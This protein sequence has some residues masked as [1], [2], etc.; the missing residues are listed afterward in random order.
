[1]ATALLLYTTP[2]N[3]LES[4]QEIRIVK[5]LLATGKQGKFWL[6]E[7]K[8]KTAV[9]LYKGFNVTPAGLLVRAAVTLDTLANPLMEARLSVTCTL[10]I[11]VLP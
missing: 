1:M 10:L 11:G 4:L 8:F 5:L 9:P 2:L 7:S 6:D 3:I